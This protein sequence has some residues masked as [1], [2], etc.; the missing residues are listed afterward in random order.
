MRQRVLLKRPG[1][2]EGLEPAEVL[3][4]YTEDH[5]DVGGPPRKCHFCVVRFLSNRQ[6][7]V[8]RVQHADNCEDVDGVAILERL[9]IVRPT[10]NSN[11]AASY[12]R[13][14]ADKFCAMLNGMSKN[15]LKMVDWGLCGSELDFEVVEEWIER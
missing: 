1:L 14:E 4:Y 6:L 7:H 5:G 10:K 13:E 8:V 11:G 12:D 3:T 15:V 9:Y 2:S